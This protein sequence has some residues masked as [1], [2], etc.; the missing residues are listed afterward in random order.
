MNI[1]KTLSFLGAAGLAL[2]CVPANAVCASASLIT[3]L[4]GKIE[5]DVFDYFSAVDEAGGY[6]Y[7]RVVM[8]S[9]DST[10]EFYNITEDELRSDK[11]TYYTGTAEI[12]DEIYYICRKRSV[13]SFNIKLD[14]L[15]T[16]YNDYVFYH[17][18]DNETDPGENTVFPL[19]ELIQAATHFGL[20]TGT[21]S[22][23]A[24]D[25]NVYECS[26]DITALKKD[27]ED[28][29]YNVYSELSKKRVGYII[30]D[31]NDF[32]SNEISIG[33]GSEMTARPEG[34]FSL[35]SNGRILTSKVFSDSYMEVNLERTDFYKIDSENDITIDY[36]VDE[37]MDGKFA[38]VYKF[39]LNTLDAVDRTSFR[40]AEKISEMDIGDFFMSFEDSLGIG[41]HLSFRSYDLID[42]Y[43]AGG[44][45]YDL[46][47]VKYYF[48]GDTNSYNETC[49]FAVRK[50]TDDVNSFDGSI[51]VYDHLEHIDELASG[52]EIFSL[53]FDFHNCG[54][55]GTV[56]VTKNDIRF[57]ERNSSEII[58]GDF[59]NDQ[60][61]DSLDVVCA[62]NAMI[63]GNFIEDADTAGRIDLNKDGSFNI[64]DFVLLQSFVLGKIK[65]FS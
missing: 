59:N 32:C 39:W 45:E 31:G 37:N 3:D 28:T 11:L 30:L 10:L 47:N 21:L 48:S 29:P 38:V 40:I 56:D 64:A 17:L 53:E 43:T 50:D 23:V 12:G 41:N 25:N 60:R 5:N 18:C 9:P 55:A 46:Y 52:I 34:R 63:S 15:A 44:H 57:V 27:D 2:S 1:R 6:S 4:T 54:A 65:N 16:D 42:S 26:C 35:T 7:A 13:N 20:K 8:S 61:I 19:Y 51:N 33:A 22:S 62:R 36:H 24:L 14:K 49:Y 58:A